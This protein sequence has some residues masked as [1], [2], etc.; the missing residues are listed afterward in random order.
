M[1][2]CQRVIDWDGLAGGKSTL[3]LQSVNYTVLETPCIN[4]T[5]FNLFLKRLIIYSVVIYEA[6][7]FYVKFISFI[8]KMDMHEYLFYNPPPFHTY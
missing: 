4:N 1:V 6:P 2:V 7:R 5:S 3:S 8:L